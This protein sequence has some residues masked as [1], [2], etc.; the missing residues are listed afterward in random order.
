MQHIHE[1]CA[2][3]VA[4]LK[5]LEAWLHLVADFL[6]RC[7]VHGAVQHDDVRIIEMCR[8]PLGGDEVF[9]MCEAAHACTPSLVG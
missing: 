4:P 3:D 2:P 5:V 7:Q 8:E 9:G 6:V 1:L